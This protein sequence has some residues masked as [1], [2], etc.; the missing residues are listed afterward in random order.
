MEQLYNFQHAQEEARNLQAQAQAQNINRP[1]LSPVQLRDDGP[2]FV[3]G[4][5]HLRETGSQF[6]I[7]GIS[8]L[9]DSFLTPEASPEIGQIWENK[10]NTHDKIII[11]AI[12][13]ENK[14]YEF[15]RLLHGTN[16]GPSAFPLK[17]DAFKKNYVL[18]KEDPSSIGLTPNS[19]FDDIF[20]DDDIFKRREAQELE[21]QKQ[22]KL[23]ELKKLIKDGIIDSKELEAIREFKKTNAEKLSDIGWNNGA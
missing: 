11:T 18:Y 14:Q 4:N 3:S 8:L 5:T 22:E 2:I 23:K 1:I 20:E 19:R 6:T 12:D 15:E 21:E 16:L 10:N 13:L 17:E 9:P 7:S